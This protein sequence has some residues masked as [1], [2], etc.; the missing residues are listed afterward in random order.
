[1][2]NVGKFYNNMKSFEKWF[3]RVVAAVFIIIGIY[4]ISIN[5]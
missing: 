2:A 3:K 4:Y 5:I 1:V